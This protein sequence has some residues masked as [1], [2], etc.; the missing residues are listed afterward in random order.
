MELT[1]LLP[2]LLQKDLRGRFRPWKIPCRFVSTYAAL[3]ASSV[4]S[5]RRPACR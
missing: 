4:F 3:R 2:E 5:S 1:A